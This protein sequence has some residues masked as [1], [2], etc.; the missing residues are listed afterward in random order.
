MMVPPATI[1]LPFKL[2]LFVLKECVMTPESV[3]VMG[4]EAMKVALELASPLLFAALITGLIL[5]CFKRVE[6]KLKRK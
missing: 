4:T 6:H 5:V 1:S 2:M 3:M